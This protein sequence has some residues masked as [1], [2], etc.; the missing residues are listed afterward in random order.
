MS[1]S[2][3]YATAAHAL[4]LDRGSEYLAVMLHGL[5]GDLEQ[6]SELT[7]DRLRSTGVDVLAPD[8]RA[9]GQTKIVGSEECFRRAALFHAATAGAGRAIRR[10]VPRMQAVE[11]AARVRRVGERDAHRPSRGDWAPRRVPV[12]KS[13]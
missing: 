12:P 3:Q 9:H 8:A 6:P 2:N 1:A 7:P 11:R 5:G 10:V 4:R 13:M